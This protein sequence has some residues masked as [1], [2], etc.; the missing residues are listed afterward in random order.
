MPTVSVVIPTHNRADYLSRALKTVINQTYKDFEVII[1][2]D[3]STDGTAEIVSEF[4]DPRMH[5]VR[6]EHLERAEARD[7]GICRAEGQYIAFLDDDD[8]WTPRRLETMIP[9]FENKKVGVV[10]SGFGYVDESDQLLP[11][12]AS[13]PNIQGQALR[14]LVLGCWFPMSAAVVRRSSLERVGKFDRELVPAEDWDLWVRIAAQGDEFGCVQDAL[15]LYRIHRENSTNALD[16]MEVSGRKLLDKTF[17]NLGA[18]YA[19][20]RKEAFARLDLNIAVK[21]F[22]CGETERAGDQFARAASAFPSLLNERS[23]YFEIICAMQ[24][25]GYKGTSERLDLSLG[26]RYIES[27]LNVSFTRDPGL[28][29]WRGVAFG[30]SYLTLSQLHYRELGMAD[31]RRYYRMAIRSDPKLLS[32]WDTLSLLERAF[33]P[34]RVIAL[35]R[36]VSKTRRPR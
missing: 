20:F 5:I 14:K 36:S 24:P 18:D 27:A 7:A 1:V 19:G 16:R 34:R 30:R 3:G 21:R 29:S 28:L 22:G 25:D 31:A 4:T 12:A 2:D 6:Q 13:R 9:V 33:L 11:Q 26:R 32:N 35:A 23:T 15:F 17:A 10:Y 8:L